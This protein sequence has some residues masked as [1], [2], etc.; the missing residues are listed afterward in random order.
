MVKHGIK[1]QFSYKPHISP[2]SDLVNAVGSFSIEFYLLCTVWIL[3]GNNFDCVEYLFYQKKKWNKIQIHFRRIKT[4]HFPNYSDMV[5][6]FY[7]YLFWVLFF[8]VHSSMTINTVLVLKQVIPV[9]S[10]Q[11]T[12]CELK[13]LT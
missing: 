4:L 10:N 13:Y 8:V 12:K 9:I 7:V 6:D 11:I 2:F 1:H 5:G 3:Y